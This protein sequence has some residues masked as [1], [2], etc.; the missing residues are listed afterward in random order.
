MR[1]AIE[2]MRAQAQGKLTIRTALSDDAIEVSVA[3]TGP[4]VPPEF[5]EQLF[6][7]FAT[8]KDTGMGVGLSISRSIVTAHG[9]ELYAERNAEGGMVFRFTLPLSVDEAIDQR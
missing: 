5:E 7:P 2:A 3:D 8:T 4:G 1:N 9:G 6:K